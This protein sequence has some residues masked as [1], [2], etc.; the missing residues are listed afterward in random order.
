MTTSATRAAHDTTDSVRIGASFAATFVLSAQ[1]S[2]RARDVLVA[3]VVAHGLA[4]RFGRG[5]EDRFADVVVVGAVVNVDVQ[6]K[7][8]AGGDGFPEFLDQL[9]GE[10]RGDALAGEP[11]VED[12]GGAAGEIDRDAGERLV[13]R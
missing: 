5:L 4:Q 7:P 6:V 8:A 3:R 2:L 10:L 12:E 11:G 1:R 13:H 9:D